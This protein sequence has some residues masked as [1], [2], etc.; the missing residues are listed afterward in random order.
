M[1]EG[2]GEINE[3]IKLLFTQT[4]YYV[5]SQSTESALITL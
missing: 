1:C 2:G 5:L 4:N 3:E